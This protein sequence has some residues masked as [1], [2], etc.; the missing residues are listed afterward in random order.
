MNN[1]SFLTNEKN[2][3]APSPT[4]FENKDLRTL[5]E[6]LKESVL[7]KHV[8]ENCLIKP[9]SNSDIDN[10]IWQSEKMGKVSLICE[11][12][13]NFELKGYE[14]KLFLCVKL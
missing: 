13:F 14:L 2:F 3:I 4:A 8:S 6:Q 9:L 5:D 1:L 11:N 12:I 7:K 10:K